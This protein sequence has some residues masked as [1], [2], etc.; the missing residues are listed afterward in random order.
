MTL[1][2]QAAEKIY[3]AA[4]GDEPTRIDIR[5]SVGEGAWA[6]WLAQETIL[7]N[8]S[9]LRRLLVADETLRAPLLHAATQFCEQQEI[10]SL[11]LLFGS[12]ADLQAAFI[13]GGHIE[14]AETQVIERFGMPV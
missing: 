10:S 11:H 3:R 9:R 4:P 6:E 7:F 2:T 1:A 14:P 13:F 8:R 12:S 5:L